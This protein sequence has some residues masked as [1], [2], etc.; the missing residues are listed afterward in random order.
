MVARSVLDNIGNTPLV[1]MDLTNLTRINL[2]AKLEYYNPTGSVKDRAANYILKNLLENKVLK[3][4]DHVIESSSGNFGIALSAYCKRYDLKFH[5]VID[6]NI[7]P[8]NERL[9]NS[10]SYKTYKVAEHDSNGGY[11]LNRLTKVKELQGMIENSY[12]VNQYANPLNAEAYTNTLGREICDEM[13]KIDYIFIGV[14]SGGTITGVSRMIKKRFPEAKVI[15]VDIV[16]SVIFGGSPKKRYIPGIG[17][18]MIPEIIKQARI[19]EVVYVNERDTIKMCNEM[20][21]V[22]TIFAGG[23]SGSVMKAIKNYFMGIECK[24]KVNVVAI[25]PDRG[26]RYINTIYNEEWCK[27]VMKIKI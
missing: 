15:A 21:K 18:S 23:S 14:S 2:Y 3:T 17:S 7:T 25:F 1:R 4:G 19:D 11:L 9:I 5:C 22:N 20:L 26:D 6:P 16:G 13:D 24:Q 8:I 10:L 12:W 27:T